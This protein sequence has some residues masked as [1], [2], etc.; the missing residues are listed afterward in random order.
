MIF[1]VFYSNFSLV[2]S[3]E[4]ADPEHLESLKF[5]KFYPADTPPQVYRA[6]PTALRK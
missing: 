1:Y 3:L 2:D 5:Q 4:N 6:L